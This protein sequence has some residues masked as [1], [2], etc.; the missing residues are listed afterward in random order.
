MSKGAP[1][2]IR[3]EIISPTLSPLS[4]RLQLLNWWKIFAIYV[5]TLYTVASPD[6]N[7]R[8]GGQLSNPNKCNSAL[9]SGTWGIYPYPYI[10]ILISRVTAYVFFTRLGVTELNPIRK[11]CGRIE[12]HQVN[13]KRFLGVSFTGECKLVFHET[14]YLKT[15]VS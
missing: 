8:G 4:Q 5:L 7:P 15:K 1:R 14:D 3:P 11:N 2:W 13:S 9:T 12:R 6:P 10:Y